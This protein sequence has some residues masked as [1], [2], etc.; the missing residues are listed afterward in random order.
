MDTTRALAR[1]YVDALSAKDF[2]TAGALFTDDA[3]WHQPGNNRL[4]GTD[5]DRTEVDQVIDA[6]TII[7][8][9]TFELAVTGAP[10]VNGTMVA[11]PVHF[12]AQRDG[13]KLAQ[14]G[15]D[16]L[17][18]EGDRIVEVWLFSTAQDAEDAFWGH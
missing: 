3:V 17:R 13:T 2:A 4:S 16:V 1:K 10:M 9:G 8:E 6:T 7:N 14:G 12:S 11:I 15:I 18:I 5:H